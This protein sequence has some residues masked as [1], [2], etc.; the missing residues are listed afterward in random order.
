MRQLYLSHRDLARHGVQRPTNLPS[1]PRELTLREKEKV[2][3]NKKIQLALS[4]LILFHFSLIF[5]THFH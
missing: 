2:F 1:V 3:N 4:I 5:Q